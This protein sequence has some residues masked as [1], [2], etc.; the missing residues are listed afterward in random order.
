M[1]TTAFEAIE[2]L[3]QLSFTYNG[4]DRIVEPLG[5]F[6]RS[7]FWYLVAKD[8]QVIKSFK[9]V[10]IESKI[11]TLAGSFKKPEGFDLNDYLRRYNEEEVINAE[12]L[13]RKDQAYSLRSK[14]Q[15][16]EFDS[17]WDS[18]VVP[19]SYEP[20][21]VENLLWHGQNIIVKKP[22]SLRSTVISRLEEFING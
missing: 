14:Y 11:S 18:M 4:S 19:Y 1:L 7:G 21:I 5:M 15:V 3:K 8:N 12:I 6:M 9:L 22:Q 20:E 17:E 2:Q 16:K 10:R 13:V